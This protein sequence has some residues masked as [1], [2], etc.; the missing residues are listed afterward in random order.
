MLEKTLQSSLDRKE[1][2]LVNPKGNQHWI[3]IGRTNAKVPIFWLPDAKNWLI[4]KDPD[5]G[6]DWRQ[7]KGMT[8][9]KMVGWH[10][11]LNG[12]EFEQAQGDGEGQGS[13]V[14]YSSWGCQWVRH[15]WVTEQ[16]Y[17]LL[18]H[19]PTDGHHSCLQFLAIMNKSAI[20]INM[21]VFVCTCFE[22]L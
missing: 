7:E 15:G 18:T 20:M 22:L 1:I 5:A 13:L 4:G 16:C 2:R 14:C 8:E 10:H 17:N 3:L 21:Q 12:H 9:E 11:W 6:K 19:S